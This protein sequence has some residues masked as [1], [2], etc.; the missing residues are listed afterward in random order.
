MSYKTFKALPIDCV[1][2]TC[3]IAARGHL[4]VV[5][6]HL[7][8]FVPKQRDGWEVSTSR[9]CAGGRNSDGAAIKFDAPHFPAPKESAAVESSALG[10]QGIAGN[11]RPLAVG[12]KPACAR[13]DAYAAVTKLPAAV[14]SSGASYTRRRQC[15]F[16]KP[17]AY[18]C[19]HRDIFR[20]RALRFDNRR[21]TT[22]SLLDRPAGR[23]LAV[24]IGQSSNWRQGLHSAA[25]PLEYPPRCN[26]SIP[27]RTCAASIGHHE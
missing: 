18:G 27:D 19:G 13:V 26:A 3:D 10:S 24:D 4:L 22:Q 11:V 20:A 14:W 5:R 2:H 8:R 21:G 16:A 7:L 6:G 15:R 23:K 25:A 1:S 17:K 9:N 12:I